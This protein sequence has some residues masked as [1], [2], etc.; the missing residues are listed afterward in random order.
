M[1]KQV[2][3]AHKLGGVQSLGISRADQRVLA[4]LIESQIL[5]QLDSSVALLGE[6]LEKGQWPLFALM[7][8]T[9]VSLSMTRVPSKLPPQCQ[10]SEGVSLS[11]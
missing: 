7:P 10:S 1:E 2:G 11:R 3:W 9:S 6:G 5:H 4:R 8:D